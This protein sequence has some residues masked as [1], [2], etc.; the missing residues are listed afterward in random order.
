M[1]NRMSVMRALSQAGGLTPFADEDN[2]I[3]I[4]ADKEG[5]KEKIE[6]PYSSLERGQDLAKDI[7]LIPGDVV[8]VP[9]A[10]LF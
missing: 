9:T 4:R 5:N 3:V 1:N 7:D 8:V 2:I 10:G 6:V